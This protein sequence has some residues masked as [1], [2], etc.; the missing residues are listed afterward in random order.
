MS[1]FADLD[2]EDMLANLSDRR[3]IGE[4]QLKLF[5]ADIVTAFHRARELLTMATDTIFAKDSV[6][7]EQTLEIER[8]NDRIK[9]LEAQGGGNVSGDYVPLSG[10]FEAT[11][12]EKGRTEVVM[13]DKVVNLSKDSATVI[14]I[15]Y[16]S[17]SLTFNVSAA[18]FEESKIVSIVI[19]APAAECAFS[20]TGIDVQKIGEVP[21]K[22]SAGKTCLFDLRLVGGKATIQ[23]LE[24]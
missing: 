6:I 13:G 8:L 17:G 4:E 21:D 22:V 3:A 1:N 14:P 10:G 9:Q 15:T 24:V 16:I 20:F 12:F 18:A 11:C 5:D 23:G 2:F 7:N 19:M